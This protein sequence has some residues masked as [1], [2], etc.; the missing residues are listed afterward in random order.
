MDLKVE[1]EKLFQNS[2]SIADS[3]PGAM[4]LL[5]AR[6]VPIET[7]MDIV[8]SGGEV[9]TGI[10]VFNKNG[11]LLIEKNA[12]IKNIKPL[13]I[14]Q[15]NGILEVPIS[16]ANQGGLWD[17]TGR[18]IELMA[19]DKL[20]EPP[21]TPLPGSEAPA[22]PQPLEARILEIIHIKAEAADKYQSAKE[23]IRNTVM[24]IKKS[25]GK[26]DMEAVQHT[27]TELTDFLLE[28]EN[29]FSFLTREIFLANEFLF[30][31]SINVCTIGTMVL[32]QFNTHFS[33]SISDHLSSVIPGTR[34]GGIDSTGSFIYYSPE[35]IRDMAIGFFLHD[36]GKTAIPENILNKSSRLTEKELLVFK[37]HSYQRGI[38][39]LNR[40]N[41]S[42][43]FIRNI[44]KSHH[45][46][47]YTGEGGGYPVGKAPN[48]IPAYVKICRLA[49]IYDAMTSKRPNEEAHNPIRVVTNIIRTYANKDPVLQFILHA[50][51]SAVGIWP[52]GS[53]VYLTNHQMAYVIDSKGP[54]V[55]PFT[56]TKGR[57]LTSS[58]A[59]YINIGGNTRPETGPVIDSRDPLLSPKEVYQMMPPFLRKSL[60]G[61]KAPD[62]GSLGG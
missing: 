38:E 39:I 13:M 17:N 6:G 59:D 41:V 27:V 48:E 11:V 5:S 54:I 8:Q 34:G 10:D 14:I 37:T 22:V 26:F 33:Q 15:Q 3:R 50:F 35:D 32:K 42:N 36:I 49:D 31:H 56:D 53:I 46:S 57:P 20:E 12:R 44:V 7:L 60:Y 23:S 51:I 9:Q 2:D 18:Q 4:P 55:L 43:P 45:A 1:L 25:G 24:H 62:P 47:L 40:N 29:A 52:P 30:N 19:E 28:K 61:D 58:K 16:P 21:D